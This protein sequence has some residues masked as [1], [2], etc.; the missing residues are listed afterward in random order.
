M[1]VEGYRNNTLL[2][3]VNQ[4]I[5]FTEEQIQE[6]VKCSQDPIYFIEN[7]VKI[8]TLDEGLTQFKMWDFQKDMINLFNKERFSIT[9]IFR[10]A[11]KC[12]DNH[13]HLRLR[14][15]TTGEIKEIP[16]GVFFEEY[17]RNNEIQ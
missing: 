13:S 2:K 1:S 6:Y 14:N 15:K 16:I 12:F 10:Q 11:G 3:K 5:E 8:V 17:S 9:K 4:Q 7:Y